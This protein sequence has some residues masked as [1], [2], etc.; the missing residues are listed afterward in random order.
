[1]VNNEMAL[2]KIGALLKSEGIDFSDVD[3]AVKSL[4]ETCLP[5]KLIRIYLDE[6]HNY[7]SQA[8]KRDERG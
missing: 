1:M 6:I 8:H 3:S 4:S 2:S 7:S 5:T